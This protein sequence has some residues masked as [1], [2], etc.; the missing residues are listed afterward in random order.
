MHII[1]PFYDFVPFNSFSLGLLLHLNIRNTI[2]PFKH[3][4]HQHTI[5]STK[6]T[7]LLS[8]AIKTEHEQLIW[9]YFYNLYECL[10]HVKVCDQN[11]YLGNSIK[12]HSYPLPLKSNQQK[13]AQGK[14][15][16][17]KY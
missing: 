1:C 7:A 10:L 15:S 3:K 12:S 2:P 8:S 14:K 13:K 6:S 11:I 16:S 17:I 9:R 4:K 5:Q